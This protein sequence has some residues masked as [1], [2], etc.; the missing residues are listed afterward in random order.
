MTMGITIYYLVVDFSRDSW[1][2]YNYWAVMSLDIF[3]IIF[4]LISFAIMAADIAPFADENEVC[5]YYG[6]C[7]WFGYILFACLAA[8]A[9]LGGVEL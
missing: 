9:G 4:W 6:T 8:V 1:K 7:I 2:H 3:A 5:D